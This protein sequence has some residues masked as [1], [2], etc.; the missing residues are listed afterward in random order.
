MPRCPKRYL[1]R[2]FG[3]TRTAN[4][5]GSNGVWHNHSAKP[6]GEG[7]PHEGPDGDGQAVVFDLRLPMI[8]KFN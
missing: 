6:L 2:S 4:G 5:F 3:H 8:P 7:T 1:P